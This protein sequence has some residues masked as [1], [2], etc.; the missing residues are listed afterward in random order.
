MKLKRFYAAMDI[1]GRSSIENME[2]IFAS[3]ASDRGSVPRMYKGLINRNIKKTN[4]SIKSGLN[5]GESSQIKKYTLL[6]NILSH[7]GNAN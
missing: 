5:T 2:K 4:N 1:E 7:Q 3:Y 6:R